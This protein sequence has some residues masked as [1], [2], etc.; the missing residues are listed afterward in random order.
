[1]TSSLVGKK[2]KIPSKKLRSMWYQAIEWTLAWP[3]ILALGSFSPKAIDF[4]GSF[5]YVVATAATLSGLYM[6]VRVLYWTSITAE[7]SETGVAIS[8]LG[9]QRSLDWSD[10]DT[11]DFDDIFQVL[12][13]KTR[14]G[15]L[16]GLHAGLSDF[17]QLL[18]FVL[19]KIKTHRLE[20][21]SS[22]SFQHHKF[23]ITIVFAVSTVWTVSMYCLLFIDRNNLMAG[24]LAVIFI[25]VVY[26]RLRFGKWHVELGGGKVRTVGARGGWEVPLEKI[27]DVQLIAL[28]SGQLKLTSLVLRID[29]IEEEPLDI[30]FRGPQLLP[31]YL[32]MNQVVG[33]PT[34]M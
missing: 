11:L 26:E 7:V 29:Q 19:Q 3:F 17:S 16:V 13:L 21:V 28:E 6:L 25:Y 20:V 2:L 15:D 30:H 31:L 1:M 22:D 24:A 14:S 23:D 9:G 4:L 5:L 27:T 18:D 33:S 8:S 34:S 32:R 10:V 12:T